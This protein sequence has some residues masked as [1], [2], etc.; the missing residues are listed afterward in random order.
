MANLVDFDK[1]SGPDSALPVLLIKQAAN[2]PS[3][4][5]DSNLEK[6]NRFGVK[7]EIIVAFGPSITVAVNTGPSIL[8]DD[9][10]VDSNSSD[11]TQGPTVDNPT[12]RQARQWYRPAGLARHVITVAS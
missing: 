11:P 6:T 3:F 2:Q 4:V 8:S 5:L 1:A 7:G 10:F 9:L 12:L